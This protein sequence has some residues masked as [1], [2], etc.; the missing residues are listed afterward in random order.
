M[1]IR[2]KALMWHTDAAGVQSY[3]AGDVYEVPD[4]AAAARALDQGWAVRVDAPVTP[5]KR[6]KKARGK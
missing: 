4:A 1:S 6:K 2:L 3:T 5:A